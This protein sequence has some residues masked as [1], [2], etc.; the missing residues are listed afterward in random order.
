MDLFTF[1]AAFVAGILTF[2]NP[3]VLPVLPIVFGS[4]TNQHR[5]G[6][7]ALSAGLAL[8]FTL[9]G[10][11]IATIGFSLG[12]DA[13]VFRTVSAVLLIL[14]GAILLVPWAQYRLQAA[15]GPI[16]DWASRRS[17]AQSGGTVAGQFMIGT[18]LGAMWS[19]CVGPTLGAASLL[20][21]QGDALPS[22]ALTMLLFGI[23]ASIP[24]LLIGTVLRTRMATWRSGLLSAGHNGKRLLGGALMLAG[25][26]VV[27]GLDKQAE[28]VFL[29]HAPVW[30]TSLGTML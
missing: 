22:V 26:L 11:F 18:L 29:D 3:C 19:P 17:N 8:S 16:S 9:V 24:L 15:L 10:L 5:L 4:A 13:G 30:L 7:L 23:G 25:V 28:I 1:G 12:L 21:A 20:A 6:P 27:S 14:F 2:L